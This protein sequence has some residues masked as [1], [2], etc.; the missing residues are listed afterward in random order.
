MK[1]FKGVAPMALLLVLASPLGADPLSKKV[2]VDFYR[3]VP[4]RDLRGLATRSDGRLVA[5][6]TL[7]DLKGQS[8]SE[9]LWCLD[10][11]PGGKWIVGGGPGGRI[12]E[13][14]VDYSGASFTSRDVARIG[15]VQVY[16]VRSLPD[17]S[18]LA[19]TSP[20]GGLY[21]LRSGKVAAQTN[22]PVD[23]IF[24][25]LILDSGKA[26]LVATGNPA[27]IYK[28][29]LG[30]FAASGVSAERITAASELGGRGIAL[31]G[32]ST[33]RNLRRIARLSDGRVVAG[34]APRGSIFVFA[35]EGGSPYI[36]E[37]NHDAEVTDL[38]PGPNGGY[39]AAIVYSGGEIHPS[40]ANIQIS[41]PPDAVLPAV[42]AGNG[43]IPGPTP[44]PTPVAAGQK[45]KESTIEI[46]NPLPKAERFQGRSALK[47]FSSDGFPETLA[48]R[49]GV[50]FYRICSLGDTLVVSGGEL[51]E[52]TG[53]DLKNRLTLTFPG[54]ASEQVNALE[55]VPG[56]PGKFFGVRNN[57][58][59][60]AVLDFNAAGARTAQTKRVD[61]GTPGKL[62]ALRFN[63]IRELDPAQLSISVRTTNGSS[64]TDGWSPWIA[65][66]D[67]D[68]WRA[69]AP[70]GRYVEF[71]LSLPPA[72]GPSLELDK[73]SLYFLGQNHRP[74]LQ[75]FRV[76]SPNFAVVV[77]PEM[78]AP[79]VT[80]VGQLLQSG[81]RDTD[82]RKAALLGS[83]VVASTGTR[84][85]FWSVNDP[86]GDNLLYTFSIRRD[87]TSAWT[88]LAVDTSES[89]VQFD[90][91]HLP[92]GTYFTRLVAKETAPRPEAD[93]LS[94]VFET[95]DLI[96]DHTPPVIEDTVVK[97][98][99]NRLL[100]SVRGKDALSLLDSAEFTFNNGLHSVVEQ[101]SDGILDG[102]E[103]TFVLEVALGKAAGATSVEVTLYDAAG[104]GATRRLDL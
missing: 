40:E 84:V 101:P 92:E 53:Y 11:A 79:V 89:Y 78:P 90:T 1:P 37:E 12:M 94:V 65:M 26:A 80:T 49:Q 24:D 46:V 87:G 99:G 16:S 67:D 60:F 96:V 14:T 44:T 6:P 102:R 18:I 66:A 21:L 100:V 38:A 56:S 59:G 7:T 48:S 10:P 27:R 41:G 68:G 70:V 5:G 88:D 47:W 29:D 20:S 54:S 86:D 50:A 52:M 31:F 58:P 83:Q 55:P 17:G 30:K 35:P 4:S 104:N 91:L 15:E 8:P 23:S 97:R 62:G 72:A 75:D 13:V 69:A 22:L 32:E 57:A 81:E 71:K 25:I 51:G 64:E 2:D 34:S 42:S 39:Y 28:I 93:R 103:E 33:D 85:I 82:R 9:L 77:P 76:L 95:D 3:D 43:P 36:A 98:E 73:A 45:T 74:Q 19:G 61:L 63:R